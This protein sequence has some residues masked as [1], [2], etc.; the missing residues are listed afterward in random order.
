MKIT[1]KEFK[2]IFIAL[3]I[4]L[5]ISLV[6]IAIYFLWLRLASQ[7]ADIDPVNRVEELREISQLPLEQRRNLILTGVWGVDYYTEIIQARRINESPWNL[8]SFGTVRPNTSYDL[9]AIT[10]LLLQN[11]PHIAIDR[12]AYL[13]ILPG[14]LFIDLMEY[15]VSVQNITFLYPY[16]VEIP[17]VRMLG[18]INGVSID[19]IVD[20]R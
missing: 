4:S 16:G 15:H 13:Q 17:V 10:A 14:G 2:T 12:D 1:K 20:F 6:A 9:L 3:L 11:Y 8:V 19:E 18:L 5:A 7:E